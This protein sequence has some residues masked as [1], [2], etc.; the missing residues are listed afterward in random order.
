[1]LNDFSIIWQIIVV[2]YIFILVRGL[3]GTK[4]IRVKSI[5]LF[6]EGGSV[7]EFG[8]P[9]KLE[10]LYNCAFLYFS[11]VFVFFLILFYHEL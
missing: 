3:K 9:A 4:A 2:V 11:I 5:T 1:M 6:F 8:E 7:T 10:E